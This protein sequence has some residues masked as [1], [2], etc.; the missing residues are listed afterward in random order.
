[1]SGNIW[2]VKGSKRGFEGAPSSQESAVIVDVG[3]AAGTPGGAKH[4]LAVSHER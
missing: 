1:M 2:R 4:V 3:V